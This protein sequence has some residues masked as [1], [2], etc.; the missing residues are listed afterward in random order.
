MNTSKILAIFGIT[1]FIFVTLFGIGALNFFNTSTTLMTTYEAKIDANRADFDNTWK[2][3]RQVAQVPDKYKN[4]FQGVYETY[5]QARQGG[6]TG[7][8]E[9][10]S[11]LTEA[12]PQYDAQQLYVKVQ[13]VVEAK[14]ES[15]T[16]RQKELRDL[17]REHDTLLRTFPGVFYNTFVGH[18]ELETIIITSTKTEEVFET[19]MDND[20]NLF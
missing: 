10:L 2:T 17:K 12:V 4:D 11:F 15:W 19:R 5:M 13:T 18:T 16:M 7:R 3:I 9:L 8:G 20:T 1:S 6:N 14:R